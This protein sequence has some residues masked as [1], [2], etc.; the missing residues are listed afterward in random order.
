MVSSPLSFPPRPWHSSSSKA[1]FATNQ[2]PSTQKPET[3]GAVSHSNP[4]GALLCLAWIGSSFLQRSP[5]RLNL[6]PFPQ[7]D[8]EHSHFPSS[9]GTSPSHRRGNSGRE[10]SLNSVIIE[11]RHPYVSASAPQ[12]IICKVVVLAQQPL[13]QVDML[14]ALLEIPHSHTILY[15]ASSS[16]FLIGKGIV[17]KA[18]GVGG[19]Y[20]CLHYSEPVGHPLFV[21]G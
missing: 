14:C 10:G 12:G 19:I 6:L 16:P 21:Y 2:E 18:R 5:I 7:K 17:K 9:C 3:V 8:K 20:K 13:F 15:V 4:Y 1:T 11:S